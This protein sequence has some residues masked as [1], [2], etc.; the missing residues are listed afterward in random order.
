MTGRAVVADD[1]AL[2]D[3]LALAHRHAALVAVESR[4]A[5]AVVDDDGVAVAAHHTCEHHGAGLGG[6][7]RRAVAAGDVLA[8][9]HASPA[10]A[11]ARRQG[12]AARPDQSGRR[13]RP[14]VAT[15]GLGEQLLDVAF[16]AG[17]RLRFGGIVGDAGVERALQLGLHLQLPGQRL[18]LVARVLP[19]R[20]GEVARL[21]QLG[22]L[23][24]LVLQRRAQ[25]IER[26]TAVG[27]ERADVHLALAQFA[28]VLGLQDVGDGVTAA[29]HVRVDR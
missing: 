15:L 11:E 24:R 26:I 9:V 1:V 7:D 29:V 19:A 13:R 17:G 12:S 14:G 6:M 2:V 3:V 5:A 21:R 4:E 28:E 18:Q 16:L 22:L 25:L 20:L 27:D 10:H 23:H 8:L